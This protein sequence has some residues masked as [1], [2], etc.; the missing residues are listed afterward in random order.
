MSMI[1]MTKKLE[2]SGK[3]FTVSDIR[4]LIEGLADDDIISCKQETY[5]D[6]FNYSVTSALVVTV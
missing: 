3:E 6:R 4:K 2:V 5:E 1:K